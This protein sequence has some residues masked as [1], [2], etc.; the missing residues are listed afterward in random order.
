MQTPTVRTV[1]LLARLVIAAVL[2][3][4][5]KKDE[6]AAAAQTQARRA[7]QAGR[8]RRSRR[9]GARPSPGLPVKAAAGQGRQGR[10]EVTAVGTLIAAESVVIRPEIAGRVVETALPGRPGGAEGRQARHVDR[11]E[12]E[13]QL[14]QAKAE[15]KTETQR[16]ER[17]KE[18]LKKKFV[19][20][21]ALD[22]AKGNMDRALAAQQQDEVLLVQDHDL[23]AVQRHR[24]ACA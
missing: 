17:T 16:Y 13:A 24:R 2:A 20:Q 7:G 9:C 3:G 1:A 21:E 6:A 19:S 23:C 5:G 8:C 14:G 12:Y 15:A 11:S 10:S 18:L 4:C 22:V